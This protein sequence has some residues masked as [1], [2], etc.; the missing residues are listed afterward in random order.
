MQAVSKELR[1]RER[2]LETLRDYT[3]DLPPLAAIQA[4]SPPMTGI[5]WA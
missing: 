5:A 3:R 2:A 4:G 1:C